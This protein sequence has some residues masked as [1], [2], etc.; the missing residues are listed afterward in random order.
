MAEAS[1]RDVRRLL[2]RSLGRAPRN[3]EDFRQAAKPPSS[4]I[5]A[6]PRIP[7]PATAEP[8][9]RWWDRNPVVRTLAAEGVRQAVLPIGAARGAIH[10]AEGLL[11]GAVFAGR[12]ANPNLDALL[13]PPGM[14]ARDNLNNAARGAVD[15]LR[16]ATPKK[17]VSDVGKQLG[18]FRASLD[19]TASP[20]EPTLLGEMARNVP[21]DMNQGELAFDVGSTL[22]GGEAFEGL[23][24]LSGLSEAATPA[25]YLA[26]GYS[27]E[28]SRYLASP[29]PEKS[30]GHHFWTRAA[31]KK[32]PAP[33]RPAARAVSESRFSV[34]KP[35]GMSRGDFYELHFRVDPRYWGGK[36]GKEFGGVKW[37]GKDLG[38]QKH[39]LLGRIIDGSPAPLKAAVISPSLIAAG[40]IVNR[41]KSNGAAR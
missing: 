24:A 4:N 22:Y 18:H 32:T 3:T 5:H 30:M 34:L 8:K 21:I 13:S 29:L 10:S 6:N 15:Y 38:W 41:P 26:R 14:S 39:G 20:Q 19:P 16:T 11:G 33:I 35:K 27:P 12:L 2:V 28:L 7:K 1:R 37:S 23:A 36:A 9:L 25:K 31:V 17:V 40:A